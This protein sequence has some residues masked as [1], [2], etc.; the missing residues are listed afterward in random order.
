MICFFLQNLLMMDLIGFIS[1]MDLNILQ[2][3]RVQCYMLINIVKQFLKHF[4]HLNTSYINESLA[5]TF[6]GFLLLLFFF[7][8][9][10]PVAN[11]PDVP[12]PCGLLYYP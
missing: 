8:V 12:K 10:L 1:R 6:I 3:P 7:S 2:V 11:T 5:D 4:R 9:G